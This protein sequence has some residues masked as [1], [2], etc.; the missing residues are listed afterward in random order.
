[1]AL[2]AQIPAETDLS[3][4]PEDHTNRRTTKHDFGYPSSIGEYWSFLGPVT[5]T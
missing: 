4:A 2:G 1:M 5:S 3:R